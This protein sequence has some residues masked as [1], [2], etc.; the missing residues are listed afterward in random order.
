MPPLN[1]YYYYFPADV[2]SVQNLLILSKNVIS[3]ILMKESCDPVDWTTCWRSLNSL[4]CY[5]AIIVISKREAKCWKNIVVKNKKTRKRYHQNTSV[6]T[7]LFPPKYFF[8]RTFCVTN[9]NILNT[10]NRRKKCIEW[11]PRFLPPAVG[12]SLRDSVAETTSNHLSRVFDRISPTF[13]SRIPWIRV[14][15]VHGP[16]WTTLWFQL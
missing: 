8:I 16:G 14:E 5:K 7:R 10:G 9:N 6:K 3:R 1:C 11:L 4:C 12:T 15:N 13:R 2:K